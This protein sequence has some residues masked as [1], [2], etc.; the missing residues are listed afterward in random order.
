MPSANPA[1]EN[2]PFPPPRESAGRVDP[3]T[4]ADSSPELLRPLFVAARAPDPT[5]AR[6]IKDLKRRLILEANL[7]VGMIESASDALMRM[8]PGAAEAVMRRDDEIDSE[9]VLIEEECFRLLT[10]FQPFAKD[11]RTVTTLLRVNADL[12]RVGDHAH[13]IAK[14]TRKLHKLGGPGG[15][16]T[17]VAAGGGSGGTPGIPTSLQELAQRVPML[18]HALLNALVSEDVQNARSILEKDEAIDSLDKRLFDECLQAMSDETDSKA[19]GLLLY[20]CGR[21][22]ERVGDLMTNIAEDVLYLA[23]GTIVRHQKKRL[24]LQA[25]SEKV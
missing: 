5:L 12:E 19:R 22:L 21:E 1:P 7:A 3:G 11:F 13:S 2:I 16:G 15:V 24:R 17:G 20:R 10:L 8:D 9:E 14:L 6:H 23:T 4:A 25:R 18:C